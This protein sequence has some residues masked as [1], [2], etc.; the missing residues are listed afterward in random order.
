MQARG[1]VDSDH[2]AVGPVVYKCQQK[3]ETTLLDFYT[4][5]QLGIGL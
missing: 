1:S 4:R 3:C 5:Y 2:K